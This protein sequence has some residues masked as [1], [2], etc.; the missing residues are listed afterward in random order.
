M[1]K[2]GLGK[3]QAMIKTYLQVSFERSFSLLV[4][5][6]NGLNANSLDIATGT[7]NNF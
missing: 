2:H 7:S 4:D 3:K 5:N 1:S 6:T